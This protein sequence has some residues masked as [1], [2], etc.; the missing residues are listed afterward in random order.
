V[1]PAAAGAATAAVGAATAADC[2]AAVAASL[3]LHLLRAT[4]VAAGVGRGGSQREG[5]RLLRPVVPVV[6]IA[7]PTAGCG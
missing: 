5:L 1:P 6:T 4:S 2:G 3:V 7:H